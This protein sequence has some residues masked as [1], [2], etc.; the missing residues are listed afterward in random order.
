MSSFWQAV[1]FGLVGLLGT[2]AYFSSTMLLMRHAR[3]QLMGSAAA[4]FLLVVIINYLL[5]YS[6]TFRSR[7]AHASAVLRF[8]VAS[9]G[10][11]A[12]NSGFLFL[13]DSFTQLP[14]A[15]LLFTGVCVVVIWNYLLAKFWVFKDVG[16]GE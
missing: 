8:L 6:W 2:A 15:L 1:R 7:R 12:I 4:S 9:S 3:M 13:S 16:S 10:G 11:M 5:H 14:T